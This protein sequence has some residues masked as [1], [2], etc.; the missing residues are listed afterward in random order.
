MRGHKLKRGV[1]LQGALQQKKSNKQMG[2][3]TRAACILL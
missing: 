3:K 2:H 1:Y